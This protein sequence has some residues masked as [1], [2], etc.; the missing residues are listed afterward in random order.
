MLRPPPLL[1]QSTLHQC[2][3]RSAEG[4]TQV[5]TLFGAFAARAPTAAGRQMVGL[6][7]HPRF[8]HLVLRAQELGVAELGCLLANLLSERDLVRAPPP[9][10]NSSGSSG[11]SRPG[12][13]LALRI[14]V[15]AGSGGCG[16]TLLVQISLRCA[17]LCVCMC[18]MGS[19][20]A[21]VKDCHQQSVGDCRWMCQLLCATQA[22][23][24]S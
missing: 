23:M 15:L 12:A 4:H 20:A 10:G 22:Y 9:G 21:V 18:L 6:G 7:V 1:K 5:L 24:H 3:V 17:T 19:P 2:A 14:A 16:R 13:D 11:A 8:A